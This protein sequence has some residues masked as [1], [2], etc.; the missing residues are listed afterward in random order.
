MATNGYQFITHWRVRASLKEINEILGDAAGLSRWWPSVY[1]RVTELER[2]DPQSGVG[3]VIDLHTKGWLPYTLR[4]QLKI[5]HSAF[6]D[7]FTL[8]AQGDFTGRGEWLFRQDGDWVEITYHWRV[9]AEK[10]L[11][12]Y[13]SFAMRPLFAANHKW[14][15]RMG[16]RSLQLE[17]RRRR[18]KTQAERDAVPPPPGPTFMRFTTA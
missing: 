7:G 6:P 18:A 2:G 14:A 15:M 11:L 4:W 13:L 3:R 9:D 5:T 16:E 10:P 17:L 12:K 8:T 1:L